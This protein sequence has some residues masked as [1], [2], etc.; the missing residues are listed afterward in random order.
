[1]QFA[2][3]FSRQDVTGIKSLSALRL[4]SKVSGRSKVVDVKCTGCGVAVG[5]T[6]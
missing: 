2:L 4:Q 3:E 5:Q 6:L 1:M